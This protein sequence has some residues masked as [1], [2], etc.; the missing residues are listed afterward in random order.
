MTGWYS[1]SWWARSLES[2][3]EGSGSGPSLL[4]YDKILQRRL[5]A[6]PAGHPCP[7]SSDKTARPFYDRTARPRHYRVYQHYERKE[8]YFSYDL[9]TE[10]FQKDTASFLPSREDS[11]ER[12][13]EK[14]RQFAAPGKNV[15]QL[16]LEHLEAEQ[17]RFCLAQL[18]EDEQELIF[19]LFYQEK[20]EQEVGNI[21]HISHQAVNKRKRVLLL[22]LRK[23]FEEFF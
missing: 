17:I 12:L 13:L 1:S 20:T 3:N 9:K 14:D 21:L 19:L 16:A 7:A 10:K 15:E 5:F 2:T 22:K 23:I 8:E 11:Y 4:L 6:P 18:N